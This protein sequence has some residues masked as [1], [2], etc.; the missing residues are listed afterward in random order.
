MCHARDCA[1]N[2]NPFKATLSFAPILLTHTARK[3]HSTALT[4]RYN[5]D[6]TPLRRPTT[7][8]Q[9]QKMAPETDGIITIC[10]QPTTGQPQQPQ[11]RKLEP[12]K[13]EAKEQKH[14]PKPELPQQKWLPLLDERTQGVPFVPKARKNLATW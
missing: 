11:D 3:H 13:Q 4:S 14:E 2:P 6:T 10:F 7:S 1:N 5:I 12:A 8:R 9:C